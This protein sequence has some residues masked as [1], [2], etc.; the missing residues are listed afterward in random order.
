MKKWYGRDTGLTLRMFLTMFLLGIVYLAFIAVLFYFGVSTMFIFIFA[1]LMLG[2][3]YFFSDKLVLWTMGAKMVSEAEAPQ[4][5]AMVERLCALSDLPKPRIAVM[6][7]SMPNAFAT[8]RNPPNA[9]VAV[10]TGIM[11]T[12]NPQE[13]EG[14]LAHE[15][16]HIKNRDVMVMT[17]A[18]FISTV[19]FYI[20]RMFMFS[21][22]FGGGRDRDRNG[23]AIIVVYIASIIVW[24]ISFFLIRALS[25]YR[26][27]AAD[28]GSAIITG[29]PSHLVTALLKISGQMERVPKQDLRAAEGMNQFFIVP[30]LSGNALMELFSTHPSIEKRIAR[31][32]A[33]ERGT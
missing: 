26:E 24:L 21:S 6:D 19:A 33:M 14:V 3:Q 4:L 5:H 12:L 31:L 8:G 30:A 7:T 10:T 2:V 29:N 18:S 25:R 1:A 23:G 11:R 28:R 15:L 16:S 17:I 22:M 13:L 20:M 27:F 32:E 9:V